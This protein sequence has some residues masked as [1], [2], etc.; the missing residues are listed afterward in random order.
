VEPLTAREDAFAER[1]AQ[2]A[3]AR[4][5]AAVTN[6]EFAERAIDTY[7]ASIQRAVGRAVI[8][9][10]LWILGAALLFIGW[11]IGLFERLLK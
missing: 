11:K 2:E 6:P 5:I 1:V 8:K 7:S 4:M 3:T 9:T 10:G